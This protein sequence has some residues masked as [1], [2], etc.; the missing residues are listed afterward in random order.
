MKF[1]TA[2]F[3]AALAVG[4]VAAPASAAPTEG[5][6]V[7][8]IGA[9]HVTPHRDLWGETDGPYAGTTVRIGVRVTCPEDA[10]G[11]VHLYFAGIEGTQLESPYLPGHTMPPRVDCTGKPVGFT[12]ARTI[13]RLQDPSVTPFAYFE[14]GSV[15]VTVSTLYGEATDTKRVQ[16]IT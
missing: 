12:V 11:P 9:A 8:I 4:G 13:S 5:Y 6:S 15:T 16:V 14:K 3:L 7:Q 1:V 2:S 10:T